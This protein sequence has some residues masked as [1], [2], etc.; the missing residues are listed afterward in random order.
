MAVPTFALIEDVSYI[1]YG[2]FSMFSIVTLNFGREDVQLTR[3][4]TEL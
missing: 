2:L 3:P 1:F 4:F